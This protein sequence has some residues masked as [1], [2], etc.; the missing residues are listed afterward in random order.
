[1]RRQTAGLAIRPCT[2]DDHDFVLDVAARLAD[3]PRPHWRTAE[4]II[5]AESRAL[6][7]HFR[8]PREG[9]ALLIAQDG[10]AVRL[11]FVFLETARDYFTGERHGHVGMLAVTAE[12]EGTGAGRALLEAAERWAREQH[13]TRLSLNVFERN[14]HA[15]AVYE[16]LGYEPET[17]R[18]VKAIGN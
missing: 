15:R 4:Q 7:A 8:D 14:R 10:G 2:L 17:L 13:F 18:Y 5:G 1:M 9:A 16:H 11:G 6:D 3:F 12:S